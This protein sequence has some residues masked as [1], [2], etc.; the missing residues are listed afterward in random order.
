MPV[1]S[2]STPRSTAHRVVA[3]LGCMVGLSGCPQTDTV[4]AGDRQASRE[5]DDHAGFDSV[6]AE[7]EADPVVEVAETSGAVEPAATSETSESE[8]DETSGEPAEPTSDLPQAPA[9]YGVF[10]FA[11]DPPSEAELTLRGLAGYEIVA[12]H[13]QP[14]IEST[15]LGFLRIGTRLRVTEKISKPDCPKGWYELEGGGF[16]CASKG[17]VVDKKDPYL[18]YQPAK[19][20]TD[21]PFP[22]DWAYVRRWNA[23]MWWRVPTAE[24]AAEA[25]KQRASRYRAKAVAAVVVAAVVVAAAAKKGPTICRASTIP[26]PS[27]R[28]RPSRRRRPIPSSRPSR[29]SRSSCRSTPARPGSRRASSCRSARRSART[30]A[31]TGGPLAAGSCRRATPTP[32]APRTTRAP[33]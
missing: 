26:R 3:A 24:E 10:K 6:A 15:K 29:P 2:F 13:A 19:A 9:D 20:R 31:A 11:D 16:A 8:G 5:A 12:V 22:Y 18:G 14:D 21:N 1:S 23:P 17:L 4:P 30:A 33:C 32:T 25:E 28:L 7:S 27:R